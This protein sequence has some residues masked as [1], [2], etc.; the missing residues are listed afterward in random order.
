MPNGIFNAIKGAIMRIPI[1]TKLIAVTVSVLIA[2]AAPITYFSLQKME[3][4]LE[5]TI[6]DSNES[7][8]VTKMA[9]MEKFIA[10]LIESSTNFGQTMYQ[11][12]ISNEPNWTDFEK[13]ISIYK[14]LISIELYKIEG[15]TA[16]SISLKTKKEFLTQFG[17]NEEFIL[18][19]RKVQ[20]FPIEKVIQGQIEF[21]NASTPNEKFGVITMGLPLIKNEQGLT[22]YLILVDYDL[23]HFVQPFKSS[24]LQEFLMIDRSGVIIGHKSE[25]LVMNKTKLDWPF[26]EKVMRPDG[27]PRLQSKFEK[28]NKQ[29]IN[30]TYYGTAVKT[31][32]GP[33]V[34][35]TVSR[36]AN[37]EIPILSLRNKSI[38]TAGTVISIAIML[39]FIFSI[40]LT[41][42]IETLASLIGFVSKGR[43]DI[44]ATT[45]V[46]QWMKDEVGELAIAFDN[47]TLGLQERD[48]VKSLFSKFHGSSVAEEMMNRDQ[49]MGGQNK[50]VV[51]FFSD[52][53]GFTAFSE[54]RAPEEVVEML[55]EYFG[56]M[57]KVINKNGGIVD[58][59][60]GDAIMAIWG[61]P[62]SSDQDP[63]NAVK[64]CLEMRV[65]LDELN[66]KRLARGQ[67]A[68][69]IGMGLHA[70]RA[71]SGTIGSDERMEYTVIG[72]TINT[73]SRIEASTKAFGTDLLISDDVLKLVGEKFIVDKAGEAEVKGR[74]EPL[75]LFKVR[76]YKNESGEDVLIKTPYSDYEAEGADK[77]KIKAS[78]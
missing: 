59:F 15:G 36:A 57:V 65:A 55:N 9:E 21:Q 40:S 44:K 24:G 62:K 12:S 70:G 14:P 27:V 52:I 10:A 47:M 51:V 60:I 19:Q 58:K 45:Q 29:N 1:S 17:Y 3:D 28:L 37:I 2:V 33:T 54:K 46:K 39:V 31:S 20:N 68:I 72:N 16:K 32:Y 76:G 56:V 25:E 30:E 67:N 66:Q 4:Q 74:S 8:A 73:G 23:N 22:S 11:N 50:E 7:L 38:F 71:I 75:K 49:V 6:R 77:V 41:S 13:R 18:N 34:I 64:A 26:L 42:P 48:K 69:Q 63:F 61:A 35:A 43:F 78:H 53:R 5:A